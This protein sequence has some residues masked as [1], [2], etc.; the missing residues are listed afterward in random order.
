MSNESLN[1]IGTLLNLNQFF[2]EKN[3]RTRIIFTHHTLTSRGRVQ[4]ET[5]L[6]ETRKLHLRKKKVD[7]V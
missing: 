5:I 7:K 1:E 2:A 3:T 6:R 4:N